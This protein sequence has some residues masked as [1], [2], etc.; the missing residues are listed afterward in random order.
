MKWSTDEFTGKRFG[1]YEVLCRLAVG[2]MAEIFLGFARQGPFLGKAVVLKRILAEQREDPQAL[3]MLIDEAKLTA[4]LSH[5][6]VA[7]VIDLELAG[8]DVLLVIEFIQGANLEELVD[9]FKAKNEPVPLGFVLAVITEAAK[10]L[11]VAHTNKDATGKPAPIIHRDVT[12]RNIMV[13]F[14]GTS[15]VLD[16]GIAR[17]MGSQRR[18]VAGMVRGTTAYMS[19]EQA[20]GKDLD[21]RTDLF[22]LGT[23]FHELLVGQ[24]LF[25]KGNPGAEMAAVYE[26][27]I[28]VPSKANRRVPKQLDTVV[29]KALE[30]AKDKRYQSASDFARDIALAAGATTWPAQ[31]CAEVVRERFLSRRQDVLRLLSRIPLRELGAST[32]VGRA[33]PVP[34]PPP[35]P[36]GRTVMAPMPQ[37]PATD[38]AQALPQDYEDEPRTLMHTKPPPAELAQGPR[39]PPP[40]EPELLTDPGR[41]APPPSALSEAALFDDLHAPQ[42]DSAT[43]IMSTSAATGAAPAAGPRGGSPPRGSVALKAPSSPRMRPVREPAP[44]PESEAPANPP[45]PPRQG[46]SKLLVVLI[47]L[48]AVAAGGVGGAVIY[49]Q[50]Q[51]APRSPAAQFGRLSVA[52]DRPT[53][54]SLMGQVLGSTPLVDVWVPAGKHTLELKE[55]DGDRFALDV[56]VGGKTATKVDVTLDSLRKLP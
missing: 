14:E 38:Q 24:R 19:P 43:R 20:I 40:P 21:P 26:G 49:R 52:T 34:A 30:R 35:Y 12:P 47:A 45:P 25:Y 55:G 54:V 39:R 51:E 23:I 27:E 18:T 17:A 46:T 13:D 41:P 37:A 16:F 10:G 29:M 44:R 4:T 53:E 5:P 32:E 33:N 8:E 42:G 56:E 15:K 36:E 2:G 7:Q 48:V 9:A 50:M 3:Q 1:K 31:K 22:S 28:P 6:N 11:G